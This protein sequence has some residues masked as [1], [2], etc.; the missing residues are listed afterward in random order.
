MFRVCAVW[1]LLRL[2]CPE[3]TFGLSWGQ[4]FMFVSDLSGKKQM[5]NQIEACSLLM[6]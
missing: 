4:C 3:V 6:G 1:V 2:Y 5:K